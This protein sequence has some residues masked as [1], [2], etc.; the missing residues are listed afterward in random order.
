MKPSAFLIS[1]A[2]NFAVFFFTHENS[3]V[4]NSPFSFFNAVYT[5]PSSVMGFWV[6]K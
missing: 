3:T 1:S 4:S 5:T 2:D 6:G